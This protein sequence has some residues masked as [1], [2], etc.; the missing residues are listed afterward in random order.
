VASVL[1][2]LPLLNNFV[3]SRQHLWRHGQIDLVR[4]FEIDDELELGRMSTIV[5]YLPR[6]LRS[7]VDNALSVR[8]SIS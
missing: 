6:K 3:R 2:F 8:P 7:V 1:G 5:G 4:R